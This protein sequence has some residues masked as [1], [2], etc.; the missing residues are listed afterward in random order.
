MLIFGEKLKKERDYWKTK[1][2]EWK[3]ERYLPYYSDSNI[4]S[5]EEYDHVQLKLDGEIFNQ[6]MKVCKNSDQLTFIFLMAVVKTCIHKYSELDFITVGTGL[7]KTKNNDDRH[8]DHLAAICS[9]LDSSKSFKNVV[10][11]IQK[12]IIEA[13]QNA[14]YP[15]S[16][17]VKDLDLK[18][19]NDKTFEIT[20]FHENIHYLPDSN[21]KDS[22][23]Q[24]II[25]KSD[26]D[27][28]LHVQYNCNQI[29]KGT[30]QRFIGHIR[31][32]LTQVIENPN[33]LL[34]DI[35]VVTDQEKK[36]LLV[37]FNNTATDYPKEKMIYERFEE[38]VQKI[39]D[40]YAIIF[41]E[42]KLTYKELNDRANQIANVLK[43]KGV[44]SEDIV[45]IMVDRS[46]E[47]VV[48]MLGILKAGGAYLPIDPTY[49]ED[50]KKF[51]I[52][53]ARTRWLLTMQ[54]YVDH[55]SFD[56][57][58]INL[59]DPKLNDESSEQIKSIPLSSNLAY[60]MYTS[61]ST[62]KP[63]GVMITHQNVVSL[64]Q[65]V[66]YLDFET[67][68][69]IL[70][71][72]AIVFDA[73]TFEIWGALLNGLELIMIKDEV[74]TN[75]QLLKEAISQ[76]TIT[77]LWLTSPLFNQL[78]QQNIEMFENLQTLITGGDVLSVKHVG[79]VLNK[80]PDLK[81]INGYGPT[82][83]TTFTTT[84][85]IDEV[86]ERSSIPIG[87][88]TS[89]TTT[90]ILNQAGQLQPIGVVGELY[91]GGDGLAK[92]YLNRNSL[93]EERFIQHPFEAGKKI[94]KTGDLARWL[95][96]GNIEYIGRMDFQVKVRGFRI[97][98]GEI[99][100]ELSKHPEIHQTLVLVKE[101]AG[102][103][104]LCAYVEGLRD[105][106]VTELREFIT[107]SLPS[108][109][110]PSHFIQLESFPL[111][112]SGKI[113][114]KALPEPDENQ[115][116]SG[117]YIAPTNEIERQFV[118]IWEEVLGVENIGI[119]DNFFE[120]GGHSL[121]AVQ[122]M[123]KLQKE[124]QVSLTIN[125]IFT[126]PTIE[127]LV[128]QVQKLKSNTFISMPIVEEGEV[129]P[130]SSA[131]KR[132]YV[133]QQLKGAD[134]SYNMPLVLTIKGDLNL[135][136]FDDVIKSLVSRHES[137]RTS[138]EIIDGDV[139]QQIHADIN[140]EIDYKKVEKHEVEGI[141][142]SLIQPFDLKTAPLFRVNLIQTDEDEYL[143]FID[144]H[145]IIS[146]G[147]SMN[148]L[149]EDFAQLYAGVELPSLHFQY[150]DFAVWQS[151]QFVS[152][153]MEEQKQYWLEQ[154]AGEIPVL[155]L[156]T[157]YTRPSI[158]SFEGS[159]IEFRFDQTF[160]SK[161]NQLAQTTNSTIYM[162]L[163]T[164]FTTLL[165]KYTGQE[166]IIV[167]S[168]VAGRNHSDLEP[169]VGMFVNTLA[170]R[171]KPEANKPFKEFLSEVKENTLQAMKNESYPL[172]ELID[173]LEIERVTGR[174]PLF[175]V[176]LNM[177][178]MEQNEMELD[179]LVLHPYSLEHTISKFDLTLHVIED[180][181]DLLLNM[182]YCT[183]L[184]KKDTI[185]RMIS[186]FTVLIEQVVTQPDIKLG[187]IE[188]LTEQ[189][190]QQLL[191][192]FN[193]RTK[194]YPKDVTIHKLFEEQVVKTP[195]NI[196]VMYE[197]GQLTYKELNERTNQLA[198]ALKEKGIQSETIV[199]IM[200]DRSLE[201]IIAI[202]GVLKAGGSYVPIDPTY[203]IDRMKFIIQ[204]SGINTILTQEEWMSH[205]FKDVAL[206][207]LADESIYSLETSNL[208]IDIKNHQLAYVIYTS[209]ST[210]NPKGVLVEHKSVVNT[211]LSMQDSY[212]LLDTDT[213]LLKTAFTF[214]VSVTELFGYYM[215]G[216]KLA[217]LQK[218]DEKNPYEILKSIEEY[219]VTHINFVPSM[220]NSVLSIL[221]KENINKFNVLKY[222][223]L[224]GEAVSNKMVHDFYQL[225]DQVEL[226]NIY[227][228]T[229]ATIYATQYDIPSQ[230]DGKISIGRPLNNVKCFILDKNL[231]LCPI[232][233]VGE[234]CISGDGL[235]RGYL[236][237]PELNQE[238]F[239]KVEYLEEGKIYKTG[240][241]A[242]WLPDGRI[243]YIGRLDY[244]VKIRGFRIELGEI[245]HQLLQHPEIQE[246]LVIEIE[247]MVGDKSLCAYVVGKSELSITEIKQFLSNYLVDY[248]IPTYFVQLEEIPLSL[249][250]KVDRKAL[251][252]PDGGHHIG[253]EYV[254]P[255]N[256][257]ER[258]FVTIWEDVLGVENIGIEDNFFERG[259]HSLKAVQLYSKLQKEL[260][261][262][263]TLNDIFSNP[264]IEEQIKLIQRID[265]SFLTIPSVDER[266][267]YPL[268]SAQ[269]RM[270]L[271][272]QLKGADISY[273]M[274]LVLT[275]K[276]ELDL[277]RFEEAMKSLVSRH[278]S[279][280]T[281]FEMI[282]EKTVQRI[283]ADINF[284]ISYTKVEKHEI[285]GIISSLIQP[286]DLKT[287]PLFRV[288][289]IQTDEDE[290][291]FFIDMHHIISDGNSMNILVEDFAQLYAGIELPSLHVQYKDFAVWQSE[292]FV[293]EQIEEQ[294][295]YWLEQFVGEIPV[296]ELP[297]DYTRPSIQSFEGN[298][299]EFRL[300][301]KFTTKINQLAQV[302]NS[303]IYMV[304]LAVF[305]TL[306]SKY[307]GQE[308]IIVGSPV[309]GRNH[310]DIEP[311]VGMFVNTLAM[312]NKPKA[313][314]PFKE[315]L[316]E[317]KENSLQAMKNE[318]YPL[319][320]LIDQLDI[321]RDTGRN[322]LF[323][324]MLNMMNME[325]NEMELDGLVLHPYS[326]EHTISKFDLTLNVIGDA[327]ELLLN[328]EYCTKLFK[329]DTIERMISHFT[330]LIEQVVTQ[331]DIKLGDIE[332]L[333]EQ[334]RQ[335]L[336]VEFNDTTKEYPKDITMH[337][338]FE[339]Q[340]QK[341]PDQIAVVF[342]DEL[343]TYR[344]LNEKSNQLARILREKGVQSGDLVG[345]MTDR[346]LELVIG[347]MSILKAGAAY[348]PIDPAHP[349]ERIQY[350]LDDSAIQCVLT[351]SHYL[352]LIA[353]DGEILNIQQPKHYE[354]ESSNLEI[355]IKSTDLAY[356]IYTSGS[357]GKPKGVMVEHNALNNFIHS[358]YY[359]FNKQISTE[360]Q[361]LS[362]TNISFD[363]SVGEIFLPLSF[364]ASLV[365]FDFHKTLNIHLLQETIIEEKITFAYIPPTI[366]LELSYLLEASKPISMNK[367]LVGVEPIKDEVLEKYMQL[368]PSMQIIN[369]YGPSEATICSNFYKYEMHEPTGQNVPI[370]KPL[371]NLYIH[372]LDENDKLVPVGVP[373]EL[374]ISGAGLA[375]GY[376]NKPQLTAD[377]FGLN[378]YVPG[379]RMYRTG[380]LA[381]WLPDGNI[382]Y[383]GRI[384][385]QVKVR[386]YRVEL[387]EIESQLLKHPEI[388]QSVVVVKED[389]TGEKFL[390][391]YVVGLKRFNPSELREHA[392]TTL[393]AYM[394]PSH[395]IQ[396]EM[397]PLTSNG[398]I[399]RKS[400]PEPN[401]NQN[402]NGQYVAPT[403]ELE[404]NFAT[405][406]EEIL[407]VKNIGIRDNFFERGGQ[408]L[409][410]VQLISKLQKEHQ[411]SLTL[412]DIFTH[413]TIEQLV[414]LIQKLDASQWSIPHIE[415]REV[416]PVSSAQKRLY[417][418][419]QLEGADISYNMPLVMSMKGQLNRAK[420]ESAMIGLVDRHEC[421]RT[422]FDLVDG[423]PVQCIHLDSSTIDFQVNFTKVEKHQLE[424]KISS[425]IQPFDLRKAPLFRVCLIQ[426]DKDEHLF[427]IDIHH[428]IS[429]AISI[430]IL[431]QDFA[432][433]YEGEELSPLQVQYKD[434]AIWQKE[435]FNNEQLEE[436]KQY[437][438]NQF[439]G[440]IPVLDLP[441]D[442]TRPSIQSFEG[443]A[444]ELC[445]D[446][447][448]TWKINQLAQSTNST[449]Y[450]V[451][452]AAFTTLLSKY[453]GQEDIIVG[454]PVAGRNH[455]D[456]E[457]IVGMFV[458]T[459]PMRNKPE[460]NKTFKNFL[461]EVKEN[462]LK[463]L[464][465][466][467]YPLE[468][469]IEYLQIQRDMSRNPLFSV[470]MNMLNMEQTEMDLDGLSLQ[471]YKLKNSI[472]KF[473]LTLDIVEDAGQLILNLEYCTKLFKRETIE[474]MM[475]HFTL[476]VEQILTTPEITLG[477]INIVSQ[478]E[479][480]QMLVEFNETKGTYPNNKTIHQLF[481]EQVEKKPDQIAVMFEDQQ[482][483]F[484]ELN[485]KANQLAHV[486]RSKGV[487]R[488]DLVGIMVNRSLEM[489]IGVFGI[490]K[491]GA[492]YVPID[493]TYPEERINYLFEDSQIRVL[494]SETSLMD[495]LQFAGEIINLKEGSFYIG[496][497]SNLISMSIASD[498]AYVIYTSGSTGRPKGVMIKHHSV[499]N[500][501]YGLQMHYS[502]NEEDVILQK[503]PFGFD[504]SVLEMFWGLLFGAKV[505]LLSPEYEKDP[506]LIVRAIARYKIT[507]VHFV[508]SML[509]LFFDHLENKNLQ[510]EVRT[511]KR[512]FS[513]GEKLTSS[514][515]KQF[516]RL[517]EHDSHI[518]LHNSYG[519]T[520]ASVAVSY[521]DCH[522]TEPED[523]VPIGK[524]L[525][526]VQFYV[527][528]QMNQLQPIGV[529]GELCISGDGL[530]KGYL[531]KPDITKEKFVINPF[532]PGQ[533]MYKT[534]D[535]VRWLPDGNIEYLG[536][537]DDQVKIRGYRIELGEIE[538]Q[539]LNHSEIQEAVVIVHTN[540][541]DDKT[542]VAYLVSHQDFNISE[543]RDYA[544]KFLPDYMVPPH[545]IQ[546]EEMP[547]TPNGKMD[548]KA[549][550]APTAIERKGV[551]Y[552]APRNELERQLVSLWEHVLEMDSIS[553]THNFFELGGHS[554]KAVQI[555][556]KVQKEL[557]IHLTLRDIFSF[558]TVQQ[559]SKRIQEMDNLKFN[560]IPQ[561]EQKE[562]YPASSAQKR[563]YVLQQLENN[564]TSYNM[565]SATMIKGKLDYT[566]FESA[567]KKLLNRHESLRT[568]FE[569]VESELSQR[570]HEQVDFEIQYEKAED[571][572][573][574]NALVA[575]FIQPFD[576]NQAPLIRVK[577][578]QIDQT[579]HL[580]VFDMHH[581][582]SD[583]MSMN[584]LMHDFSQ[585]YDGINLEDLY[586][587]YKDIAVW[588]SEQF[589]EEEMEQQK[590][591][592]L[593]QFEGEVP[594]LNL[595]T[596][597][598]RP[599][600]QSFEGEHIDMKL[601]QTFTSKV[602]QLA[603]ETNTTVYMI[604]L[605][606]YTVLLSKYTG[607]E[608][609]IVGSP[610]AGRNHADLEPIVGMFVN[611]V[612][613][614][615]KPNRN[616]SFHTFLSEVKENTLHALENES[617]PLE[618][619]IENLNL[620]RDTSRNPLFNV[621]FSMLNM[622]QQEMELDQISFHPYPF[623]NKNSK[624]DVTLTV[625]EEADGLFI[626]MEYC[627]KLFKQET[628]KRMVY[629]L[630]RVVEQVVTDPERLLQDID[631]LT[632]E[633]KHQLL[634]SFND[635]AVKYPK[636]QTIHELFEEQVQKT[637]NHVAVVF[638]D[639]Q[640]TYQ[641][642]NEK[643]NQLANTLR[644]RGVKPN[645]LV[646]IMVDRSL[647]MIVGLIGILKAGG[648]YVPIDPT[649]PKQRI[650]HILM[651]SK[652]RW[653]L[654]QSHYI[655]V[656][657]ING[658]VINLEDISLYQGNKNNLKSLHGLHDLAYVIYTSGTT[659]KPKGVL[660]EHQNLLNYI[661]TFINEFN[662]SEKDHVLQQASIS[663]DTS[664]EEIFPVLV[665]GGKITIVKKED[666]MDV[667][668]LTNLIET[669]QTSI[670]SCSPLLLNELNLSLSNHQVRLFISGG[671]VLV[672]HHITN[673]KKSDVYN[674]YGPTEGTVCVTYYKCTF[675]EEGFISIGKPNSNNGVLILDQ[676]GQ[677]Q[678]IG[679][680]GEIC[681]FGAGVTRGYL[682]QPE[683]TE[684]RFIKH[685]YHHGER[686]YRTGDLAKW[687]PDGNIEYLGRIDDQVKIRG[688]RIELGEIENQLLNHPEIQ[689][690]VVIVH[691]NESDDK[692]LVAYLVSH[693]DFN[694]SELR[695]YAMKF[696]P[697][698]MVPSHFIQLEEMPLTPNGKMDRKALPAPTAIERKGVD[699]VAPR[700]ELERQLVSLWEHVLEMDSI[701]ITHNFFELGGHSIKAVQ[702]V[703]KV[704]KELNIHLTLRDIFS[705]PTVQ[706]LSK[707]IQEMD[708]LKF[709]FIPQVEQK[710]IYPA[711]SA[712]KRMY[713]LQQL[714]NS[715]TSYNMP[716]AT[717]IK[718]KL[719]YTQF[720]S[721]M[722]KLLNRHESLRTS[723]EMVESELSQR[724]HEQVDFEIQY[725][726]AEDNDELNALVAAFIQP[727]DLNQ[728]PLIRVK[729]IQIDQTEHLL[730][731]DMHHIISDGMSMN[732]LMHDFSQLYDGINLED[733]YIQYKDVAVWQSEQFAEEEME[734]QKQ[735]WL[736]QFEGEVPILNLPTDFERPML[737]SF[738]GEN[739]DMKLDQTITSKVHRL[740]REK[741]TTVYMIMLA[742]Y[743]VLLS[744]YTGQ[745]DI[746]VGSPVAGRNHADLEPIVGMFVNS[747]A[748]RN[749]PNRNQPFHTFL[750]E[751]KENT[752]HA[753]ENESYPLEELIENLNLPRDT[754]RNPLFNVMFNMLNMKQQEM[755]L[756]QI[757]FHPYPMENKISKFDVTLTV[758]EEADGLFINME[759]CTKLFKQETIKRMV[760]HLKRVVEQVVTDPERLLQDIDILTK[761]EK[762]Q[763]LVS[764]NDTAVKYP[765]D[766]TIH[767]LFEEQVQKTPNHVAVVFEDQQMTYQ[768]LND[769]ANKLAGLLRNKG[770]H[771][772]ELVAIMI[773]NSLEM[774][775][776][777]I[778]T[779]KAGAAYVPIDP[780]YPEERIVYM[781]EDS[782]TKWLLTEQ[783]YIN[784]IDF[785]GELIDL[786][787]ASLYEGEMNS[788][789]VSHAAD[790]LAYV[791]YTSGTTGNPKGVMIEHHQIVN[792]LLWWKDEFELNESDVY[793]QQFSFS[794]D[795]FVISCF[796][797][798]LAGSKLI[799][800]NGE[801]AKHPIAM[802]EKI[803]RHKVTRLFSV[804]I[805]YST[806]IE[807]MNAEETQSI[808]TVIL[809]G[810]KV[811]EVVLRKSNQLNE[812]IEIVNAYGPTESSVVATLKRKVN[813]DQM[814]T[815]GHPIGNT[816]ILILDEDKQLQPIGV[817][818]ELCISGA[819]LARGYLNRSQLTE[820]KFVSNPY[821]D[822]ERLYRTG[823]LARWLPDGTIEYIGRVDHQVKIRGFRIELGEIESQILKHEEIEDTIVTVIEDQTGDKSLCAY[824][825]C[826]ETLEVGGIREYVSQS[827]PHYMI[828]SYFIPLENMPLMTNGKVDR[829]ALPEPDGNIHT[830]IE[831]V[832]PRNELEHELL[833][834]WQTVLGVERI[835]IQHNFFE[836]G[837][838]SLKA[839]QLIALIHKNM[840]LS[841][842][843]R[844]LFQNPTIL[845]FA[846][847]LQQLDSYDLGSIAQVE[848][849]DVYPVSSAQKRMYVLQQLEGADI[850]YNMPLA[851][852]IRGDLNK[853]QFEKAIKG[854]IFRHE[855][856]R[857]SFEWKEGEPVQLIH[858]HLDVKIDY[859]KVERGQ[860][861]PLISQFIQPFDLSQAPLFRV[862][863]IEMGREEYLF[864][865]DMHHIISDG[866]SMNILI[867]DFIALYED[868]NLPE[869][870]IQ[871]KDF[872]V[873]QSEQF[874]KE[875]M[876]QQKQYWL[877]QYEDEIPVLNLPT[878]FERPML[879]S[880]EGDELDFRL[881]KTTTS[882]VQRLAKDT[883]TTVYMI[884][885]ATY[886]TLLSKYT[887][888]EDII[889]GAPVAGRTHADLES[890][891]G[892]FVNTLAI[893]NKPVGSKSF[894][895][896]LAEV[897]EN[898]VRAIEN[899][900]YP[901]EDLIEN[902]HLPRDMSRNP[903]FNVMF[904]ML[905]M[906]LQEMKLNDL[907][908]QP[909]SMDNKISK[910]DL[911]LTVMEDD[912]ELL[913]N[914]KYCTKLFKQATIERMI[915]HLKILVEQVVTQPELLLK[916]VELLS[917]Q[918][919]DQILVQFNNTNIAYP[920]HKTIH[921]LFEEQ[922][923]ETPN[924]VAVVF[925]GQSL[926][927][928]EL[929]EK[930]NQLA[931]V[932]RNKGIQANDLV[933][934]M[935]H[936]SLEMVIG[937]YGILKAGGAYV[938]INP[939]YP[940]QR[941]EFMLKDSESHALITTEECCVDLS[942]NG[943]IIDILNKEIFEGTS[944][945]VKSI[946][947]SNDLAYVL[948]TSG[949]T[950]N[951]KGV[952]I[953][954]HSVNN[955]V[956][957][958][959]QRIYSMYSDEL[960][961][962]LVAPFYFDASVK[963]I[964]AALTSGH[965]LYVVPEDVRVSGEK[966][967][968]FYD[969]NQI[970][971]SD[972]TPI[973]LNM[974]SH[975]LQ[976]R[977][978][979][980]LKHF[981]IGGDILN[982]K[983]VNEI[984][985]TFTNA[986]VTNVY[987]PT[988]CT[989]DATT[990]LVKGNETNI[991]IGKP[992]A[993]SKLY[994]MD[995]HQNIVPMGVSGQLCISG[996]GVARGYL[997]HPALTAEKFV[998]NPFEPD[999]RM[1000]L[1001]GDVAKWKPDGTIEYIG[1002]MDHQVKVRGFRI[1003]LEEIERQILKYPEMVETVVTLLKGGTGD[1004]TLCAYIVCRTEVTGAKL[1005]KYLLQSLP[1006]Y[1007]IPSHFVQLESMPLTP[1008]GKID[1009]KSLPQ[1010]DKNM[1011]K[1012]VEYV[1013][1014]R[1015]ELESQIK[1016]VWNNVLGINGIGIQ[1017]NFFE[1018]GGHSLKAMSIV[1019]ILQKEFEVHLTLRDLFTNPTIE[1020]L[1021]K[1022][1023]ENLVDN[1024]QI[1025]SQPLKSEIFTIEVEG[1026]KMQIY[1027][1028][1029]SY[1030]TTDTIYPVVYM[1031]DGQSVFAD[1032]AESIGWKVDQTLKELTNKGL[1033]EEM[1034]VIGIYSD[1035]EHRAE[1036]YIPYKES[1037]LN[1038]DGLQAKTYAEFL[1039]NTIIPYIDKHYRTI[1040]SKEHR[1041]II[1042]SSLGAVHAL[1043]LAYEYPDVFSTVGA[1044]S[1045]SFWVG[1046]R[1047]IYTDLINKP[1048]P[1049]LN[1050]WVDM[1051]NVEEYYEAT[1052][1053][1054]LLEEQGFTYGEDVF[1055]YL[1056]EGALHNE[1057]AW[1058]KRV[1059]NALILFNGKT[1060]NMAVHMEVNVNFI[1061]DIMNDPSKDEDKG[1062]IEINPIIEMDNGMKFS[1063]R[1064]LAEY[1065]VINKEEGMVDSRGF[1066][1067]FKTGENLL[1068]EVSCDGL[1069]KQ[1070]EVNYERMQQQ[1071]K[1072]I[1073]PFDHK[1074]LTENKLCFSEMLGG[1075]VSKEA[1076]I[1077][1078][1079]GRIEKTGLVRVK[1080]ETDE[1081]IVVDFQQI[1082]T[1083]TSNM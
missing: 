701:S 459:L 575:A 698:Y 730:V 886:S 35:Y 158:Q 806:L 570:I 451:L 366:L 992:I 402:S 92:G 257:L 934:L 310:S 868:E 555:V 1032:T 283:H 1051:G 268:S 562:I 569:M 1011:L 917:E 751:V 954:H 204:D 912:N 294:K 252:K 984:L 933:G 811:T 359:Q 625:I 798:I 10:I 473:D 945:H 496:D 34:S 550:P 644:D 853:T 1071:L 520:E 313:N 500:F 522:M 497:S 506:N 991:S 921:E 535:L 616:Q 25:Q 834:L 685:P 455:K 50:R 16:E 161:I 90:Y 422:S 649:Y 477:E 199:G 159:A 507:T 409:K 122:F 2:S 483:T 931:L 72:G 715:T 132:M 439:K 869:L 576:L 430:N 450:M 120:R 74:I 661:Y 77:T 795:G 1081:H 217:I 273:N 143:F 832:T 880:F 7:D 162:V 1058:E 490:L 860:A 262:L 895:T 561:V 242:R 17:I 213:Y 1006:D 808:K 355:E 1010:P 13:Y 612:A 629:H 125:D 290:Y 925:E 754:S 349:V 66:N 900:S 722:K 1063:A 949:T 142:P 959:D 20:L 147:I 888:Q 892:M 1037:S 103:K 694:I 261:I 674:T 756:D 399:D 532:L 387:G 717:M 237:R 299:L 404:I 129:Y 968:E 372:I 76:H 650:E 878:D 870:H 320:E 720:E 705:F 1026:R 947:H 328:M 181:D 156:P 552:V 205:S 342:E 711:S 1044:L 311:I 557:N 334:E 436:Q 367:M 909:Y 222:V 936:C 731:F 654:T 380:D 239:A 1015:N 243:E 263:L 234:L 350:M 1047:A 835:G 790:D 1019:A 666:V 148:I 1056:E 174:N 444:I 53:D 1053:I 913:L 40:Q 352:D 817:A 470:M 281:S 248:M 1077:H 757:S 19:V 480:H 157:D 1000:Y 232:G 1060:P 150:K 640:M 1065:T 682:N 638:E 583:G 494:L 408:S 919:K 883:N 867:Q 1039:V 388:E 61:G 564:T 686:M 412:T 645:E 549:L 212:S 1016:A 469:L 75:P 49:P 266:E 574:L 642:L 548:R 797:P 136:R 780:T 435:Q 124:L 578:I 488:T 149:V 767:E 228:P 472:S 309:A 901:L 319:E 11:D 733:L 175:N 39:P 278:E 908:F 1017:H 851:M 287:A 98:L 343:L 957:A 609:I 123:S 671:D 837:G 627:T 961:V 966:L 1034:I 820:E 979:R 920:K 511:M 904:N 624:F 818:G 982:L 848:S 423:E 112:P 693:Q 566:Q 862:S 577:L 118:T 164:A 91:T 498:L 1042:G 211:L 410:A 27:L 60:V 442:Y 484:R 854:L 940:K 524:P 663:F 1068:V 983:S 246:S 236:N 384:D 146:D 633:E 765:K 111:A 214:D 24:M 495:R 167:G 812:N 253:V 59:E 318:S 608:D 604:M 87:R 741:N 351:Q 893:R 3:P 1045:P 679:V 308:D 937:I 302:T 708:N 652:T 441:T 563:M 977:E 145:H 970:D 558:P 1012:G 516:H 82:E 1038:T 719:D 656:C 664:I 911:T 394:V 672:A 322:P 658:D 440:E 821:Q 47:M 906:E 590:Q 967:L 407:G 198:R 999:S 651:D 850:S 676:N 347:I 700:N 317:V 240:D 1048:K 190:R 1075:H 831:V 810:E 861:E 842:S 369:G 560:F 68:K 636:D 94:Y 752:L 871:Y 1054:D 354:G 383:V 43:R 829:K 509:Q 646:S 1067:T 742:A 341:T 960:N 307:S 18:L 424:A 634:V 405:I 539:L 374:C 568:S 1023:M 1040:P 376:V 675:D 601:D 187:D 453:S 813:K 303:T 891:I 543:L 502:L 203:P 750:S 505:C 277:K 493:P 923:K 1021:A 789:H 884:M 855:S 695:D 479:K 15:L 875:E 466:E 802:K 249:S 426:V 71:T 600:L 85:E 747:V 618:E 692:T 690:A 606:A 547:L 133:M 681:I 586:I 902:L 225:T 916:D 216:G 845:Q 346:S 70:Q 890:T 332:I 46:I 188:I 258:Q 325:Q 732:I 1013:S 152:E 200:V 689:E 1055:Y 385:F 809:G 726:K 680:P 170:M 28:S 620:P 193:D 768:Q 186:H 541:S 460:V 397:I 847:R 857:T 529:L 927:Y 425:L 356:V 594:I 1005:R 713:V 431:L 622:E 858:P 910:F 782:G 285:E 368:H 546:L 220:F 526:N 1014:P 928:R 739:I 245:E 1074:Q 579:E 137:L 1025:T 1004:D 554:I 764:F 154:F 100:N 434:F 219:N 465:N 781:L 30:M 997:N 988:E 776:G 1024:K 525:K 420:F 749:K 556:S 140:I 382:T 702:I 183:K 508:P 491:A 1007:M 286:F 826:S 528:N 62:G 588:Q 876:E 501:L 877:D 365:L 432:K 126:H 84:H 128:Q 467:S 769:K 926:T 168:P 786:K 1027:L 740:A 31:E 677:L 370:G 1052:F 896:F 1033:V 619:L 763:L 852:M 224:A 89:N 1030:H 530:A 846:E 176:M 833:S 1069:S 104:T 953:E 849:R 840:E 41:E 306:L 218:G 296:L 269:Q 553:I 330:V 839:V 333:T 165:S 946:N 935:V 986:K 531:N 794:F 37:E 828:P 1070:I 357:T 774:I 565:P 194:E 709:N 321:Q 595:P 773:D 113:D 207:N 1001:T 4:Q 438:L 736:K 987:G 591:Y 358:I 929:N 712:Q 56:G 758:I 613:I 534:G 265:S 599:I 761:E 471:P 468:E 463:A 635:T 770:I 872:A 105:F 86:S 51:M 192:E 78:S 1057:L 22:N 800:L 1066:V 233:V 838:H 799:L 361:C 338:L 1018:L 208:D 784:G 462:S 735:Y 1072:E 691:T 1064:Q 665:R 297:T 643:A 1076:I 241:L 1036:E 443:S 669:H 210:G 238:K 760:Y 796:A 202:Y 714:E 482:M 226:K 489:M 393:P 944:T 744:K 956:I 227:G 648:A 390:C 755:E 114:R 513:G 230:S 108:Y 1008:N 518:R 250:G 324:V 353:I 707:R 745:E 166:D 36:R 603:R 976:N 727:F 771:T 724:I 127:Q 197:G 822:G 748:I 915:N 978:N 994:I 873:W 971:I 787:D 63:K 827:L 793:L 515:V 762:H 160:S 514:L 589:A 93:T 5:H 684:E 1041:A 378:P 32:V 948:Y 587:Q 274:P 607:Q 26:T 1043:W 206:L 856:L 942:F 201:M 670:V 348:V 323:S 293:S 284:E 173:Q 614:R 55:V 209:G 179:D 1079:M 596:D 115:Q 521:Y 421:L 481:E 759:Y 865:I 260:Q 6:F 897:K 704:Q 381:R 429:D 316:A 653:L 487:S 177:L 788:S 298:S 1022:R 138:F 99:E 95:P 989:V 414:K 454:S 950:G 345:I 659:G 905:N 182:E 121:K 1059:K 844:D 57:E 973:H 673:L 623:E 791:I 1035:K 375:R 683:L 185:E 836:L 69:R 819:G 631:I 42:K 221:N 792:R 45:G 779:L 703:S 668:I 778:G 718:G 938:P 379:E 993:N 292:Q 907:S 696:L 364:G 545:F 304:L 597:F 300:D 881:D 109:M 67:E 503:A 951:P 894:E 710:E 697:D 572:D 110:I 9:E 229:E 924:H 825:V 998:S 1082:Q 824:I 772:N 411:V 14:N 605:A 419:Q 523:I 746:I 445:W 130:V 965:T 1028:P 398:K 975:F 54:S 885:L 655:N 178:N 475:D 144:M 373:G 533:K 598:E 264:T 567:M 678:P 254:E 79:N 882:K 449:V 632:K 964:F 538:N 580:L 728:A 433:L 478:Q 611:T 657:Q 58:I 363:V 641:E 1049:E 899:E 446:Q 386:G 276:G 172:E 223:F 804:P 617:Y 542:L 637:P 52:E 706:Q 29:S 932:L 151:K 775:I 96:D 639:Q 271:L 117:Q 171:N 630:K 1009:R 339:K 1061:K 527:L 169:I 785:K 231:K 743:T 816:S 995:S 571:N 783:R 88:P 996:E 392:L 196:A 864:C 331:P 8:R 499:N 729:L 823:D 1:L 1080:E 660:V 1020:Q 259:G 191:V 314:K 592:W 282:D 540:E 371:D 134:I 887:G 452:L 621:M 662:V 44:Q 1062:V 447:T 879:Q 485:E 401:E 843:L 305:N 189:E 1050:I 628:I 805:L 753:L 830:G 687:L 898:T 102:E 688:Y 280:R 415:E 377:K 615:N 180:A 418:L 859:Q 582:I 955:L 1078:L 244:Q 962:A 725:E 610:V 33:L 814:I 1073:L 699:Y 97:E 336:L 930:A 215:A 416:Y 963:Q 1031:H 801:E 23:T 235:A 38:L 396:L 289:L 251:P 918:E 395:F 874:A 504:V 581:I 807:V 1083:K 337:E 981:I 585:L 492:A 291:L 889:V 362:L 559:L 517:F 184:F 327:G 448:F 464:E 48:G 990:Y 12:S 312:R 815:I 602:Y 863:L 457:S 406:W 647:D 1029:E 288:N 106:K 512:L 952:M 974:I 340:A 969:A 344:E 256:D 428:I 486:L 413:P 21:L 536:R 400:L 135:N 119:Q 943:E 326:L 766:Q 985:N 1046:E 939:D 866:T 360:D 958:L 980:K 1002:R 922:V 163:L 267:V 903:L 295:Q 941:I 131:Q 301:Q 272:Q 914:V 116:A 80:Y 315:F 474:R 81:I 403:S 195:S 841:V 335:Q 573:E 141:I 734:Q 279:L 537:I 544:M 721:A 458:N 153:Q 551:D 476:L 737:Q 83:N 723:F 73:S 972:G 777:I 803:N 456:I 427:F 329:K 275:I 107:K 65:N 155:E 626:N 519:P 270:Y 461:V 255:R 64:V 593:K 738:E 667:H 391:S 247:D 389:S 1003:E 101:I 437:W 417:V 716:S 139:I 584:I 510:T